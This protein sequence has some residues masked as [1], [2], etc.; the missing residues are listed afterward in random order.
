MA[1]EP[2]TVENVKLSNLFNHL[3]KYTRPRPPSLAKVLLPL[4]DRAS[5][6]M[7][8]WLKAH[9]WKACVRETVP[10]VRIPLSPPELAKN[11]VKSCVSRFIPTL[12]PTLMSRFACG[13]LWVLVGLLLLPVLIVVGLIASVKVNRLGGSSI[14]D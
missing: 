7:A 11:L 13:T 1:R 6:E 8:E 5:G 2:A 9:A 12:K 14:D 10:W 3:W 4:Q